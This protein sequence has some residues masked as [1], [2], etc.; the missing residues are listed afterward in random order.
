MKNPKSILIT[1]ATSGIGEYLALNY[2]QP[3]VHLAISGRDK[4]RL[5]QISTKIKDK[6]ATIDARIIDVTDKAAMRTWI[7][8]VDSEN[9]LDL[10]IANAGIGLAPKEAPIRAEMTEKTFNVNV[11]GVF[12]TIHPAIECMLAHE[13]SNCKGQ[14]AI[15]ASLAGFV[16]MSSSP[17]YSASKN[18]VR[19]YG[20]A[21]RP[22]LARHNIAVNVICPGF[23]RSRITD[24]NKY[25]MPFF[26]E[27][28]D[29][30]KLIIRE[31]AK[32]TPRI[33]FPKPMY[34]MIRF[35]QMIPWNWASALL[36]KAPKKG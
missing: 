22:D 8:T 30:A 29:A 36:N 15:V 2:A 32:D 24:K 13:A 18:A 12:H 21:L 10:V 9:P 35:M 4:D 19:A 25:K 3:G 34:W 5:D 17:S 31:L 11:N 20:E 33:A 7:E 6:G 27:T 26:M 1:G 16:G 14:I 28:D 23:V